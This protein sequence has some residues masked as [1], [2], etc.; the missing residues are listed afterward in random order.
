MLAEHI[1]GSTPT[2]DRDAILAKLS[3]GEIDLVTNCMVL[4]EGWDQPDV[5]CIVLARPTKSM[6]L[7]RQPRPRLPAVRAI[8]RMQRL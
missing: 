8:R 6:G 4:T 3:R 5:S 1:D 2:E 7:Y